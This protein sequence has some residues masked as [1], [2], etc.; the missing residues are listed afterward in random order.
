MGVD[1]TYGGQPV[2]FLVRGLQTNAEVKEADILYALNRQKSRILDRTRRGVDINGQPFKPYSTNLY[3]YYPAKFAKNRK[4]GVSRFHKKTDRFYGSRTALGIRFDGG[5]AAFKQSLGRANVDLTGP[6]AP[7]ML[8]EIAVKTTGRTSGTMG[9]YGAAAD[10][11]EGHNIG[12]G[13][14]PKREF[15]GASLKDEELMSEDVERLAYTR[16]TGFLA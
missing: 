4:A 15:F 9:I 3:Y 8:Q 5:Y 2:E 7:H 6:S 11:A 13:H 14:L 16:L 10:R 1:V 12:A